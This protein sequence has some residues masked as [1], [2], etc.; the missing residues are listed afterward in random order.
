MDQLLAGA[1]PVLQSEK[2]TPD[3][4]LPQAFTDD[5]IRVGFNEEATAADKRL[6]RG[7]HEKI[8]VGDE[9]R[10]RYLMIIM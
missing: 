4:V 7:V 9:G 2:P 8:F 6:W 10:R 1:L 5:I 3:F